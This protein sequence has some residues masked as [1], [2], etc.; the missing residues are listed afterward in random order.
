V[1]P[2][3][4]VINQERH[5]AQVG[6][7][8]RKTDGIRFRDNHRKALVAERWKDQNPSVLHQRDDAFMSAGSEWFH[9]SHFAAYGIDLIS[10]RAIS[11]DLERDLPL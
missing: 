6:R 3:A 9:A 7:N 1:K 10:E 5:T 4:P 11:H 8:D 2:G